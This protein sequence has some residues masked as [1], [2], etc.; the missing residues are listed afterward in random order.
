MQKKTD[1]IWKWIKHR[2]AVK[3]FTFSELARIHGVDKSC[4][5]GVKRLTL[6]KYERIIADYIGVDPWDLWPDRYDA[7]HNPN[8]ISSRYQGHKHF[9]NNTQN[10][11]KHNEKDNKKSISESAE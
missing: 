10:E 8:R 5:T 9:L 2:L 3:G 4:F 1:A 6:P 7:A 11:V